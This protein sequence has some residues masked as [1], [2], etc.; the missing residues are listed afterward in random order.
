[1]ASVACRPA[2]GT[3]FTHW[4]PWRAGPRA[5]TVPAISAI[6]G[7]ASG[8]STRSMARTMAESRRAGWSRMARPLPRPSPVGEAQLVAGFRSNTAAGNASPASEAPARLETGTGSPL[9]EGRAEPPEDHEI[10]GRVLGHGTAHLPHEVAKTSRARHAPREHGREHPG[11]VRVEVHLVT[12]PEGIARDALVPGLA[13]DHVAKGLEP[14]PS[15]ELEARV[16][17]ADAVATKGRER[18]P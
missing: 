12:K 4:R 14:E 10:A 6:Q 2:R 18:L 5:T 15:R 1:M 9:V 17:A 3:P 7:T 8:D 13:H 16:G 11:R